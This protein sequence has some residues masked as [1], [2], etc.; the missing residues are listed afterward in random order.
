MAAELVK[1]FR[2]SESFVQQERLRNEAGAQQGSAEDF[3]PDKGRI[4]I[5][6]TG[7]NT[8]KTSDEDPQSG[9]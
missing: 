5:R 3:D 8:R 1:V 4:V 9:K 7:E 6:L 2:P